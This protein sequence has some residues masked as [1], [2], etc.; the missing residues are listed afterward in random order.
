MQ[1]PPK[2]VPS[3]NA[4]LV[5]AALLGIS[6]IFNLVSGI[7]RETPGD[8]ISAVGALA[9]AGLLVRDALHIKKTGVPAMSQARMLRVGFVCLGIYLIGILIKHG[10]N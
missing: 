7:T 3:P 6:G 5:I 10:T 8:I 9:Y 2:R 1:Q 4:N